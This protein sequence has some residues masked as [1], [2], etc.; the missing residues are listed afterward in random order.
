MIFIGDTTIPK[1]IE[2]K[3]SFLPDSFKTSPVIANLEG[4]IAKDDKASFEEMI[5]FSNDNVISFL[6]KCHVKAVTLANNHFTDVPSAYSH[7]KKVLSEHQIVSC[8]AGHSLIDA[9]KSAV[10][11]FE[12]QKIVLLAFG[13]DVISCKYA[14]DSTLGVNPLIKDNVISSV[15][16]ARKEYPTGLIYVLPHWDYELER[17]PMPMHR[18]L[19]KIAIDAG[20]NGVIG[21]HPHCVQGI[22]IY[23]NCPIAYSLGNWF[24]P[25]AVFMNKKT[26]FPKYAK[27]ELALEI[28]HNQIICHWFKYDFDS[29]T[30]VF[31]KSEPYHSSDRIKELTPFMDMNNKDYTNWFK[32]NRTKKKFLPV[33]MD[34]ESNKK[35]QMKANYILL[36]QQLINFLFKRGL[37]KR[38]R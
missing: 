11:D 19:A 27:E 5:L 38:S 21:H 16:K 13:W 17:Y 2:P 36:R 35:I 33:F 31:I 9:Q 28:N 30:L 8:G 23:K 37:K 7:T 1:G 22:E 29:N 18:A 3:I 24:I 34:D 25:D 6:E 15:R 4:A 20:A 26:I 32:R 12:N 14:T 10:L